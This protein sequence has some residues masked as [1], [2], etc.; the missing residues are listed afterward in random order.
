MSGFDERFFQ[1]I[2]QFAQKSFFL[3][4]VGIFLADG[5]L[6][7]LIFFSIIFVLLQ[8]NW[9]K[10]IFLFLELTLACL[11]AR[12]VVV[13]FIKFF[14]HKLRPFEFY[15]FEP[16]ISASGRAFPS[17]HV[18]TLFAITIIV[19]LFNRSW[20]GWFLAFAII[21]SI[22][23]IFVGVH[24]PFDILGGVV[25]GTGTAFLVHFLLKGERVRIWPP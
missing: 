21:S 14:Y 10:R 22:A 15:G 17:G 13:E 6:Y 3:D 9:Q 16:L 19:F 20:G 12:G 8:K 11:L 25:L 7:V 5:V 23:R 18:T 1:A 24:W 2:F 4:T